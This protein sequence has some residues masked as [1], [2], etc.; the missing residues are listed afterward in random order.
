MPP[1]QVTKKPAA[2]TAAK[3]SSGGAASKTGASKTGA[4][5][6]GAAS[7]KTDKEPE[8]DAKPGENQT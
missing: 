3:K 1:K 8:K 7:K 2:G 6:T 5:K 4:S